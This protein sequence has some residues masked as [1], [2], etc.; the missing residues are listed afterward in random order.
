MRGD[1][2]AGPDPATTDLYPHR[3]ARRPGREDVIHMTEEETEAR[4]A[5]QESMDLRDQGHS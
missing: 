5:L 1:P 3:A 2:D 4:R